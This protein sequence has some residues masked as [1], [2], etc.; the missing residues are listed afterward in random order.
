MNYFRK[1]IQISIRT[2]T[3]GLAVWCLGKIRIKWHF[4]KLISRLYFCL[5]YPDLCWKTAPNHM[6][7]LSSYLFF[8]SKVTDIPGFNNAY[9]FGWLL[10]TFSKNPNQRA[11]FLTYL[12]HDIRVKI[13]IFKLLHP[14]SVNMAKSD[15]E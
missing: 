13:F 12:K 1:T 6:Y 7:E 4:F 10:R 14:L 2:K 15:F 9:F 11:Y 3:T 5:F 8:G